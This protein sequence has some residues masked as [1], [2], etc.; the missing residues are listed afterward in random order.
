MIRLGLL[1]M[2]VAGAD[3]LN[4][5]VYP[6][7]V[8]R[9]NSIW[10]TCRVTPEARNRMLMY[11]IVNSEQENT[12]RQLDGSDAPITWGPVEIKHLGCDAGPAYCVVFRNDGSSVKATAP[13][14]VGGCEP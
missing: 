5:R 4:I 8:L 11:G 2:L 12:Q 14:S 7:A 3:G 13:V 1:L 9:G 6:S 10:L